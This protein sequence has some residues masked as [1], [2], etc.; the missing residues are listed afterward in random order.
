MLEI[1]KAINEAD[2]T[3]A[4]ALILTHTLRD[5]LAL[6]KGQEARVVNVGDFYGGEFGYLEYRSDRPSFS[7]FEPSPVLIGDIDEE[8][9][10]V[11]FRSASVQKLQLDR[12]NKNWRIWSEYPTHELL[13]TVKW[14]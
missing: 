6:L 7:N 1:E 10:T 12:M 2:S 14:E 8:N 9:V 13:R 11:I 4:F 5:A 3:A